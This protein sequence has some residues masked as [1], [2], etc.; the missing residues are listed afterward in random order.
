MKKF[1]WEDDPVPPDAMAYAKAIN[2]A[3]TEEEQSALFNAAA[4]NL[5]RAHYA[6]D[7]QAREF[8]RLVFVGYLQIY[9]HRRQRFEVE[10]H[11]IMSAGLYA[12]G[13][14]DRDYDIEPANSDA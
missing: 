12:A 1:E 5:S 2:T 7:A 3:A 4:A 8:W 10:Y 14:Y 6:G 9:N 11:N 13:G